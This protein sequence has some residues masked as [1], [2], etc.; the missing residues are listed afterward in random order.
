MLQPEMDGKVKQ[1]LQMIETET[2]TAEKIITDL[3][4]FARIKSVLKETVS[5]CDLVEFTL[6]R[7]PAPFNIS[8]NN[9]LPA[10][11]P[12]VDVDPR[13]ISQIFENLVVNAFQAM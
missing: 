12:P 9:D 4:E 6:S 2:R 3:L 7:R 1:Y 11:L 8:V 10:D 5:V 13:Q